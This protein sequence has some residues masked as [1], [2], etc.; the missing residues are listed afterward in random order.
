MDYRYFANEGPMIGGRRIFENAGANLI[1]TTLSG[2]PYTR[3]VDANTNTVVGGLNG[4]RLPW[5]FQLDLALDKDIALKGIGRKTADQTALSGKRAPLVLNAFVN[6]R[7]LLNTRQILD[8]YNYSQD[9]RD[10]GYLTSPL[11][12][13]NI[14]VQ[15]NPAAYVDQYSISTDNPGNFNLPRRIVVGFRVNF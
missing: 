6:F 2:T 10:N 9:P 12:Q 4:A 1:A 3:Y 11:G 14:P 13:Q 5:R 15:T 8:V 7:N